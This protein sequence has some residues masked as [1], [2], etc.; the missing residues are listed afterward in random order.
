GARTALEDSV[1]ELVVHALPET[2]YDKSPNWGH[3][4]NVPQALKW[5]PSRPLRTE[6]K[7]AW[8]NDGTWRK[9]RVTTTRGANNLEFALRDLNSP[10]SGKVTFTVFAAFDTRIHYEQQNWKAG[11]RLFSGSADARVRFKVILACE[12]VTRTEK[13][14]GWLPDMVFRVR[15]I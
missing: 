13:G 10:E 9:A 15:V 3:Q 8:K 4:A 11:V 12:A 2:L 6:V 7:Y 14:K 1:R 5:S